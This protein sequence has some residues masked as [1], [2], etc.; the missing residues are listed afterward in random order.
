[1]LIKN[2][3]IFSNLQYDGVFFK[4]LR[5]TLSLIL[6]KGHGEGEIRNDVPALKLANI[7]EGMFTLSGIGYFIKTH[8]ITSHELFDLLNICLEGMLITGGRKH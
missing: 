8:L 5:S 3:S 7:L 1:M 2:F 4:G 6:K